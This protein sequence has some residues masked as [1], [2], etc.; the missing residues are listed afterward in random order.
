MQGAAFR[1]GLIAV[2]VLVTGSGSAA[3]KHRNEQRAAD[4]IHAGEQQ[5][6]GSAHMWMAPHT[7][8]PPWPAIIT[9]DQAPTASDNQ[10]ADEKTKKPVDECDQNAELTRRSTIAAE[11]QAHYG[12]RQFQIGFGAAILSAIAAAFTGWAAWA[13]ARAAI[14]TD[15]SVK[16]ATDALA[17][18]RQVAEADQRAWINIE[19]VPSSDFQFTDTGG[20][21]CV[22]VAV[23]NIGKLPAYDAWC[24]ADM[25]LGT[26]S[27]LSP[28]LIS[29]ANN[30]IANRAIFSGVIMPGDRR[31]VARFCLTIPSNDLAKNVI[32]VEN[33]IVSPHV[34]CIAEYKTSALSNVFRRTAFVYDVRKKG[35]TGA[36]FI[37]PKDGSVPQV[38][39]ALN[40]AGPSVAS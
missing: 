14:A 33:G 4:P 20:H 18:A 35:P 17:H 19:I 40:N 11:I 9:D 26:R 34:I 28:K 25:A 31:H 7:R 6:A 38:L 22:D 1:F 21:F 36:M 29:A 5:Q 13:A 24:M 10:D 2:F 32:Y 15:R 37:A 27:G 16:T 3:E 8:K 30:T 23:I 39:V 12:M